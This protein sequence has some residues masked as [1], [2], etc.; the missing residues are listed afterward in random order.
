MRVVAGVIAVTAG[1]WWLWCSFMVLGSRFST[2]AANDPHGY[3]L[4]FGAIMAVPAGLVW[5]LMFPV[6]LPRGAR[7]RVFGH[8]MRAFVIWSALLFAALFTA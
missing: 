3:G 8:T 1:A 6:A 7:K 5:A 2:N 4:M